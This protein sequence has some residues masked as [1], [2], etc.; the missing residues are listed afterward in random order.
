MNT[1]ANGQ[2]PHKYIMGSFIIHG[3]DVSIRITLF[4][5][6]TFS[7]AFI[8]CKE[9]LYGEASTP[10]LRDRVKLYRIALGPLL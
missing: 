6:L 4:N 8:M 5:I 10:N 2:N 7:H 1:A 9:K 3:S